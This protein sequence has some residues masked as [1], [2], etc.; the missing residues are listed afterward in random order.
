MGFLVQFGVDFGTYEG[1]IG[2][3]DVILMQC[4]MGKV[5][6]GTGTQA[7]IDKYNPGYIINTGCAGG[8]AEGLEIGDI[9]VSTSVIEWDLDLQALGY[10]LGYIDALQKVELKADK[11][12]SD[13]K[14]TSIPEEETVVQGLI[15]SGDQFVSTEEQRRHILSNFPDALCCEMEGAAV[16]HTCEQNGVPFCIIRTL[17]DCANSDSSVDYDEFSVEASNKSAS[18]L[19]SMLENQSVKLSLP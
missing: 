3:Y 19:I 17:S 18:W 2:N 4:E 10:P 16:G 6:A 5:S 13:T 8:I 1:E 7:L 14:I 15:V 11:L 9:I 12:L